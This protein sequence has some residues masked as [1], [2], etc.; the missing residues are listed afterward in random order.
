MIIFVIFIFLLFKFIQRK[1]Y[2][3]KHYFDD[4]IVM[5]Q[6][7]DHWLVHEVECGTFFL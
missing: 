3:I 6:D 5:D 7:V 2:Y 4:L 1:N